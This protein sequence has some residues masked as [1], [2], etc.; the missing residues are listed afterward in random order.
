MVVLVVV[1]SWMAFV[2]IVRFPLRKGGDR[3]WV[4]GVRMSAE[5]ASSSAD[6][7]VKMGLQ[8]V[9]ARMER[10]ARE[11]GR[12][13]EGVRLVAVSKTKPVDMLMEAY[14]C[15]QRHFGENYAQEMVTKAKE[16]P[17][18]ILWHYIGPIQ[19]NKAKM[20]AQVPNVWCIETVERQKIADALNR[21]AEDR[22]EPL[23]IMVQVN[24]SDEESKSGIDISGAPALAEHIVKNCPALKLIGLMTIGKPDTSRE[25]E[26]FKRLIA[27]RKSVAEKLGMAS[28][29]DLELS[30][31]MS[32]DFEAAIRMGST[33]VRVGSTIFGARNY[34]NNTN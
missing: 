26:D 3:L 33:N 11:C 18:D 15:G 20:I 24:V 31:G 30:M 19:S 21:A 25:P 1:F 7:E 6:L 10:A 2:S 5:M 4:R 16:M 14:R 22:T 13:V 17:K 23:R 12:S 34:A 8:S 9:Q 32:G 28:A 27:V 29:E